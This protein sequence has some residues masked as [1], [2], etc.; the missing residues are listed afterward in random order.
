[1]K[2]I[3]IEYFEIIGYTILGITFGLCFFLIFINFYHHQD[4]NHKYIKQDT[5]FEVEKELKNELDRI[6]NN[7]MVDVNTYHGKEDTYSI[8]SVSTRL[9]TC[10][11]RIGTSEFDK[12]LAK[13]SISMKDLYEM[14]QFYQTS[15]SNDCLIKQIYELSDSS[16]NRINISTLTIISPFI[17]DNTNT[18]IKNTDYIQKILKSNSSYSFS[19]E[20]SRIDVYDSVKDSYYELLNDYKS[21][22]NYVYDIS[23]WF[24]GV[25]KS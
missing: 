9:N 1:M 23:V 3:I 5:D 12:I 4:V 8:M 16:N 17:K 20:S 13:K 11:D 22:I 14:Q 18:L 21:A 6:K 24:Q 19:S 7:S 10:V 25:I 2:K 15:I